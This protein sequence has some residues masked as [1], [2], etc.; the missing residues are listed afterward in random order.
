[1]I[2]NGEIREVMGAEAMEELEQQ[3]MMNL[4]NETMNLVK[5]KCGNV[6]EFAPG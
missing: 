5:C 4:M 3:L 6:M 1:L 2:G